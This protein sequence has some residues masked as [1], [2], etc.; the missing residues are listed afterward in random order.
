LTFNQ[1][2]GLNKC[3]LFANYYRN[4]ADV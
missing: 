2:A 4:D 1:T 3:Y